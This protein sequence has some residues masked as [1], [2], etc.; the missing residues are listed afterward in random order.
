[1][2][3]FTNGCFDV[4]HR[5]HVEYLEKSKALGNKLIVGLNSDASVQ[6]LKPGRPINTAE[7][8]KAV[9]LALRWV[10]EVIIFDEPTPLQL[11]H[12]LKPD[13]ITKGGDY[14]P[15]QVVGFTLVK[16]AVIIPFLD[17]YSS[18]RIINEAQGN[19]RQRL[20]FGTNLGDQR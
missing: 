16:R 8:R 4:L 6:K 11:I 17:G 14:K 13:I 12:R 5:G 1:V 10:D 19:S 15:E 7:D 2:I 9:L 20:G 18:T 3:V